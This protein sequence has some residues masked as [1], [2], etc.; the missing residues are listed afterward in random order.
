MARMPDAQWVGPHH[1]NGVMTRYD[2][3]CVHTIVGYAPA[4]AAHFS[5]NA[6]G[7]IFQSRDTTY[8]SAANLNG[9]WRVIA[10][11]NEDHGTAYGAW[12][13]STVPAFTTAQ[14]EAIARIC[15]WANKVHGIPL[16]QCPDSKPGSRGIAYHRQGIQGNYPNG[17]VPGGELWSSSTGKV[18]PGDRRIAQMPQIITRARQ[19]AG[20]EEDDVS[21]TD[22][23]IDP[24]TNAPAKD[25][26]GNGYNHNTE[27]FYTN[28]AAGDVAEHTPDRWYTV[29]EKT[30]TKVPAAAP[31][32][33]ERQANQLGGR[34][35]AQVLDELDGQY[36]VRLIQGVA[37]KVDEIQVG[38][39]D[40]AALAAL[41]KTD[42]VVAVADELDR[43]ARDNDPAT[44]PTS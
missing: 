44:G 37:A 34:R 16:V 26:Y 23:V 10:V 32:E 33:A 9:N 39:V 8:R 5:T 13:G 40:V 35:P 11:E 2:V 27:S 24:R 38:G 22:P 19:L 21:W 42:L 3:V 4:A 31:S 12:S 41:L 1:D 30:G 43:R 15:A 20:I 14:I 18:C 6:A 7:T 29:D 17:W 25:Y 36:L 28:R